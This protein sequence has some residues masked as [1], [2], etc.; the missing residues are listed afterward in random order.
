VTG[1]L[2]CRRER[3]FNIKDTALSIFS[4][5]SKAYDVK[6]IDDEEYSILS[7]IKNYGLLYAKPGTIKG[8]CIDGNSWYCSIMS[9]AKLYVPLGNPEYKTLEQIDE[10]VPYGLYRADIE[11]HDERLVLD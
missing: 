2:T 3:L 5:Y 9:D 7:S 4:K 1:R 6:P 11:G 10:R 8:K